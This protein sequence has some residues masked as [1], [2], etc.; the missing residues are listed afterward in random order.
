MH[1][2]G[3][4]V[5]ENYLPCNLWTLYKMIWLTHR[6]TCIP[7]LESH[8]LV[9]LQRKDRNFSGF[10][11]TNFYSVVI[12]LN[13]YFQ[14]LL[15]IHVLLHTDG[16]QW[17]SSI[18][19]IIIFITHWLFTLKYILYQIYWVCFTICSKYSKSVFKKNITVGKWMSSWC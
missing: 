8:C 19:N 4:L 12:W 6:E 15:W 11:L 7:V 13:A 10:Q 16:R 14:M 2:I 9:M 17:S 5:N 3:D 1:I 18:Y